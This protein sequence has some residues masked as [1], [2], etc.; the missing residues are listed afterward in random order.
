[1]RGRRT[2]PLKPLLRP[3]AVGGEA[4]GRGEAAA[5]DLTPVPSAQLNREPDTQHRNTE[6]DR[7]PI[8]CRIMMGFEFLIS[9][10]DL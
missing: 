8:A 10:D 2:T 5:K 3:P 1:M 9:W 4:A 6:E 7:E